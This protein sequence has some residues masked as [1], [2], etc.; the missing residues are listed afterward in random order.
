MKE[1]FLHSASGTYFLDDASPTGTVKY[2]DS[3]SVNYNIGNPWREIG[4][5]SMTLE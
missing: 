5:W 1:Y 2:K 3:S 4:T